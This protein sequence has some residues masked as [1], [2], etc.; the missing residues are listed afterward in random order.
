DVVSG[1]GNAYSDEI[2]HHARMSPFKRTDQLS[3]EEIQKLFESSQKV[4][5]AWKKL[6]RT[7]NKG[8]FP[9]KVTAFHDEMAVHGKYEQP[10]PVCETKVQRI[11]YASNEANYC[12]TCQTGGKLLADRSL[13][14]LIHDWPKTLE[15]LESRKQQKKKIV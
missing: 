1:I 8:K 11:R 9:D 5:E 10:C 15:E 13:S 14:R 4:L 2:L 3:D 7:K 12:P 6:L